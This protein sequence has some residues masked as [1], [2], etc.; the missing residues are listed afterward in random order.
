MKFRNI[1][2][3][4]LVETLVV[5]ILLHIILVHEISDTFTF[6]KFYHRRCLIRKLF[7]GDHHLILVRLIKE[8]LRSRYSVYLYI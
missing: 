8:S 3:I 5:S 2:S 6:R 7:T 4:N 1:W